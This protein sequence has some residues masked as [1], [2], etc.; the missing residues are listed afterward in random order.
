MVQDGVGGQRLRKGVFGFPC[1]DEDELHGEFLAD[2]EVGR[3]FRPQSGDRVVAVRGLVGVVGADGDDGEGGG[4]QQEAIAA[5]VQVVGRGREGL[6]AEADVKL[7]IRIDN[8][9]A[10]PNG[11]ALDAGSLDFEGNA[12]GRRV[13]YAQ[14]GV[15][16]LVQRDAEVQ[17]VGRGVL[18]VLGGHGGGDEDVD[19]GRGDD[20]GGRDDKGERDDNGGEDD[21][22]KKENIKRSRGRGRF[23]LPQLCAVDWNRLQTRAALCLAS[24]D[25]V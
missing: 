8:G 17:G 5:V 4:E 23:P 9:R 22:G 25:V 19:N 20:K 11:V 24:F 13:A 12:L 15:R 14:A 18:D 16:L 21:N 1:G 6:E 10:G 7:A 3:D 2:D